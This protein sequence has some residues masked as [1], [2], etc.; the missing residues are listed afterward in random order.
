MKGKVLNYRYITN[1]VV[2]N[3][4]GEDTGSIRARVKAGSD[5]VEGFY[6]CPECG[7]Q[8]KVNQLFKRPLNVRCEKCG[9]LLKLPKLKDELKKEKKASRE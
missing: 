1:R 6:K 5:M 8:G 2:K 4:R 9:F 3:S 7:N